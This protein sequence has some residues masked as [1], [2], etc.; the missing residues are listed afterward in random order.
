M[1]DDEREDPQAIDLEAILGTGPVPFPTTAVRKFQPWH[2]P[3]KQYVRQTQWSMEISRLVRDLRL[4]NGELRYLTLPGSDL[5][6]IRHIAESVCSPNGMTLRYLGFNSAAQPNDTDQSG[7]NGNQFSI[8][9]LA[10][11]DQESDVFPGDFRMVGEPRSQSFKRLKREG[12]FHA[13]NIDLCGGFAGRERSH[14]IPN[15][16][17]ALQAVLQNQAASS[18][19][20]LLFLTTRMDESSVDAEALEKLRLCARN[21]LDT[22]DDYAQ[23]FSSAWGTVG[24]PDAVAIPDPP[25]P[26]E[27]F[28]LGLAQWIVSRGV[29]EGFRVNVLSFMTYRTGSKAGDDD[30]VSIAIRFKPDPQLHTDPH[31]LV[32]PVRSQTAPQDREC[33]QSARIPPLV[34][35]RSLVDQILRTEVEKFHQCV[36]AS[37]ALLSATGY[38]VDSYRAWVMNE[39]ELYALDSES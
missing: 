5:L 35:E 18:E 34:R 11:V 28:M 21:I 33:Q 30:I 36:E 29:H 15:Y 39:A 12:P 26:S 38:D 4:A 10:S 7:L 20:F 14:A 24:G 27:D 23:A 13:I 19:D 1:T 8:K 6:D 16:F 31:G 22:C 3:R 32:R 2:R 25:S 9:R 17:A 37:C